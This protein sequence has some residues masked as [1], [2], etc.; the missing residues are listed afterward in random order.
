MERTERNRGEAVCP[1]GSPSVGSGFLDFLR[2]DVVVPSAAVTG[3][4][5]MVASSVDVLAMYSPVRSRLRC[6]L[7]DPRPRLDR[8]RQRKT[9]GREEGMAKLTSIHGYSSDNSSPPQPPSRADAAAALSTSS[10]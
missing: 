4:A 6:A 3:A 2:L 10:P 9:K 5:T 8:R 7:V 1:S